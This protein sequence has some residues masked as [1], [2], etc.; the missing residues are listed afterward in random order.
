MS[1]TEYRFWVEQWRWLFDRADYLNAQK[2]AAG[3]SLTAD[4][5][6]ASHTPTVQEA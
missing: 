1:D 2:T 4:P 6:T 3:E 5:A